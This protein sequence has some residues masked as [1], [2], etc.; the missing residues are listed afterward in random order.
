M[1]RVSVWHRYTA[2]ALILALLC[3]VP[4]GK[5]RAESGV[6]PVV[7]IGLLVSVVGV[8]GWTAWMMEKEDKADAINMRALIRPGQPARDRDWGFVLDS[9][10]QPEFERQIAV[11]A[12]IGYSFRF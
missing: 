5:A 9:E 11:L 2:W 4:A 10:S 3:F 1:K 12:G 7:T 8:L 6:N